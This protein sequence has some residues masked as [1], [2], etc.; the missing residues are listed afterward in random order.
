MKLPRNAKVF[1]G[2]LDVAPFM[3]VFLLMLLFIV[4]RQQIT[5]VPGLSVA[6]PEAVE[7]SGVQGPA[8][9]VVLDRNGQIYFDNRLLPAGQPDALKEYLRSAIEKAGHPVTLIVQQ[10]RE[11]K[12]DAWVQLCL[13]ARE[14]GIR[15]VLLA[16]KPANEIQ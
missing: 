7:L 3:A 11:V 10:D 6:L 8:V 1:R 9:T 5:F 15:D 16:A 14:A 12:M 4:L 2:Q 13:A